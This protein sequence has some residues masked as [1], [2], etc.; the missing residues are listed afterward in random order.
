MADDYEKAKKF[1]GTSAT[2][3]AWVD[4][5]KPLTQFGNVEMSRAKCIEVIMVRLMRLRQKQEQRP[6]IRRCEACAAGKPCDMGTKRSRAG[7][8]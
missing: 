1:F 7:R 8:G 4:L 5:D 6:K 3:L 2:S